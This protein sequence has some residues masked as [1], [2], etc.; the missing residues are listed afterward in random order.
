[1]DIQKLRNDFP[2]L[3]QQVYGRDLV[4]FDNA[5]TTHKPIQVID[6]ISNYYKT[7]NSNVHRGVHHL[8]QQATEAFELTRSRIKDYINASK[9]HEIII[10]KG[11]TDSINLVANSFGNGFI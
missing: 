2:A 11:A 3:H 6:S 9:T 7:I 8:S 10:T 4:Y 5:A 1:M